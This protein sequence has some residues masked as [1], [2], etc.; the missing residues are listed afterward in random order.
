MDNKKLEDGVAPT[1]EMQ[2][3]ELDQVKQLVVD[4]DLGG[5]ATVGIHGKVM[6]AVGLAW[7]IFQLWYASP[8]PFVLLL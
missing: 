6:L 7:V 4:A 1:A 3:G 2:L 8:L 5:R